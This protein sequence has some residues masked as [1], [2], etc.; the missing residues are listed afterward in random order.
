MALV[1]VRTHFPMKD[2]CVYRISNWR[3]RH[4]TRLTHVTS[5]R[6]EVQHLAAVST[7]NIAELVPSGFFWIQS[8]FL[9]RS[10]HEKSPCFCRRIA[11]VTV[12]DI[13]IQIST[14]SYRIRRS[15][16]THEVNNP[17]SISWKAGKFFCLFLYSRPF[18]TNKKVEFNSNNKVRI[19]TISFILWNKK[20]KFHFR[21]KNSIQFAFKGCV[22]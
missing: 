16:I 20:K 15:A 21:H 8:W 11:F 9:R 14:I 4:I 22:P 13:N 3:N 12:K 10:E 17:R 2:T 7:L 6:V 18:T 1:T 5:N 19:K